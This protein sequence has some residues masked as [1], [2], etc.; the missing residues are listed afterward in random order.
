MRSRLRRV[1]AAVPGARRTASWGRGVVADRRRRRRLAELAGLVASLRGRDDADV[2]LL[3]PADPALVEAVRAASVRA[4]VTVID[5]EGGK[6]HVRMAAL[7]PFDVVLDCDVPDERRR[8]F[9]TAFFHLRPGAAYVVPDGARELGPQRGPLGELLDPAAGVPD[10]T[11]RERARTRQLRE[12]V[13]RHVTHRAVGD[14]LVLA[15][16]VPDVLVKMREPEFNA[17]LQ[18]ADTPHRVLERIPAETPPAAPA[19]S[20]GPVPRRPPMQ[21][22]ITRAALSLRSYRDVVVAPR[23]VLVSGRVLLPDTYRHNQWPVLVHTQLEELAPRFARR[24]VPLPADPPRLSGTYLHLDNEFRGHFGHLLTESLSRAW[25]WPE[26]VRIDPD[27]RVLVGST[28][29]R[30][31]PL[32]YELELYEA[33][34]IPRDRIDV[35]D[36]PVRVERLISGSPMFSHPQFVHPRIAETWREVGDRLAAGAEDRAWPRR[37]FVSRRSD[38]RACRN[39]PE[40][41]ALFAERG[42][43]VVYP[44]DYS[45]G[46]QVRLFRAAEAIAG[47]AGSGLFQIAFVTEPTRV[48]MIG[49]D[50]YS[51]RNEYLMAAVHGHRIDA[52]ICRSEGGGVQTSYSYDE[53]RE[54]PYLRGLLDELP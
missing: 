2:A 31:R 22:P 29:K 5:E 42:F 3:G 19:G 36:G 17:Y 51:P 52:V 46:E 48:I 12:V 14:H 35:I 9:E 44:E 4:R 40:V 7:G 41:E 34:G 39:G 26:A 11:R 16:D 43:E 18:Q 32:P 27:V 8:R 49:A 20:E 54:G 21:R 10:G 45:L 13:A 30:P 24:R 1:V 50:T 33:C 15:H 25:S 28:S 47:Y 23:Q 53:E 6:R 37:F 38:K